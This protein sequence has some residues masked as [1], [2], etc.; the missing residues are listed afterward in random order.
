MVTANEKEKK[1]QVSNPELSLHAG[2]PFFGLWYPYGSYKDP[3]KNS[4]YNSYR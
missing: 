4:D 1:F 3:W 2:Y